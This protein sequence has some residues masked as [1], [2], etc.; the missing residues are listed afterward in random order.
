MKIFQR[1]PIRDGASILD[2]RRGD[3]NGDGMMEAAFLVHFHGWA[4]RRPETRI[5]VF[6]MNGASTWFH[7]PEALTLDSG[8]LELEGIERL[9]IETGTALLGVTL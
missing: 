8:D 5:L 9:F 2:S 4:D 3:F 6:A 1:D 7:C